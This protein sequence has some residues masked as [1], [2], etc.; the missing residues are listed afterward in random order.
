MAERHGSPSGFLKELSIAEDG[1][2]IK[3]KA[4]WHGMPQMPEVLSMRPSPMREEF[5]QGPTG[6]RE[7]SSL[8]DSPLRN[9]L[10]TS[11][12]VVG[13]M[14]GVSP[15]NRLIAAS[16]PGALPAL[17]LETPH[18]R[19][20]VHV[21]G[22]SSTQ[23]GSHSARLAGAALGAPAAPIGD[24]P[25]GASPSSARA[26]MMGNVGLAGVGVHS[27]LK[28]SNRSDAALLSWHLANQL[29]G[30]LTYRQELDVHNAAFEE[31]KKQVAVHCS[32][33]GEVLDRLQAFYTRS[34]EVT[35]KLAEKG[36]RASYEDQIFALQN[37]IL[38]LRHALREAED[39][40]GPNGGSS[41]DKFID[42]FRDMD[43][44]SQKDVLV[45]LMEES[46]WLLLTADDGDALTIP[47]QA[48]AVR[49]AVFA[50]CE[51]EEQSRALYATLAAQEQPSEK[52]MMIRASL[53][54]TTD[55]ERFGIIFDT[56]DSDQRKRLMLNAFA[57]TVDSDKGPLIAEFMAPL[58][59]DQ[60]HATM[61]SA[62]RELDRQS[63]MSQ[64]E[65]VNAW[66]AKLNDG[67]QRSVVSGLLAVMKKECVI[68]GAPDGV[69][70]WPVAQTSQLVQEILMV[71][72]KPECAITLLTLLDRVKPA[73]RRLILSAILEHTANKD[74]PMLLP[75]VL[76][77]ST[78]LGAMGAGIADS[79]SLETL[80]RQVKEMGPENGGKYVG[81]LYR[82][83][84]KPVARCACLKEVMNGKNDSFSDDETTMLM[85]HFGK[86]APALLRRWMAGHAGKA[87]KG[88]R[89]ASILGRD[90]G[91]PGMR[92]LNSILL[93]GAT[94]EEEPAPAV[95]K[96]HRH[97]M[98]A[99]ELR[100]SKMS[101]AS[102][103][104]GMLQKLKMQKLNTDPNASLTAE[105]CVRLLADCFARKVV[106]DIAA[107]LKV[108][109]R[110]GMTK[111]VQDHITV[112]EGITSVAKVM[113]TV[114]QLSLASDGPFQPRIHFFSQLLG[115][116]DDETWKDVKVDFFLAF[117]CIVVRNDNVKRLQAGLTIAAAPAAPAGGNRRMSNARRM[118]TASTA[119]DASTSSKN[120]RKQSAAVGSGSKQVQDLTS[121]DAEA[122]TE[123][124]CSSKFW[125]EC[126]A[127]VR[128][129]LQLPGHVLS[130]AAVGQALDVLITD[131]S[132]RARVIETIEAKA[133]PISGALGMGI[134]A[135]VPLDDVI[136]M[137][138]QGWDDSR[139]S[140]D[141]AYTAELIAVFKD[142]DTDKDGMI[143]MSDFKDLIESKSPETDIDRIMEMYD[144]AIEYTSE[145]LDEESDQITE[146]AFVL[147][148]EEVGLL[149]QPDGAFMNVSSLVKNAPRNKEDLQE[150]AKGR[151]QGGRRSIHGSHKEVKAAKDASANTGTERKLKDFQTVPKSD[152]VAEI[153]RKVVKANFLFRHLDAAMIERVIG[154]FEPHPVK[155]GDYVITQG[156]RGDYFYVCQS[157]EY[158]VFMDG[159]KVL[160]YSVQQE[161]PAP[162]AADPLAGSTDASAA[163]SAAAAVHS[164]AGRRGRRGSFSED[165]RTRRGSFA[166]MAEAS[167]K[168]PCFG[169]LALMY[170]KPRAAS[171]VASQQGKLWKLGR[172]AFRVVQMMRT[173]ATVDF[174]KVLRKVEVLSTLRFDQLQMLRDRMVER[175]FEPGDYVFRQG[176]PGDAFYLI[177]KGQAQV[178]K[179][180]S[181]GH[182]DNVLMELKQSNYF[183]ERALLRDEPRAASV[184]VAGESALATACISRSAF[185]SMLGP[186]QEMLEDNRRTREAAFNSQQQQLEKFGLG[187]ATRDNFMIDAQI[188]NTPCGVT[189]LVRH[190]ATD[191]T[192]TMREEGKRAI[193]VNGESTRTNRELELLKE[194]AQVKRPTPFLPT[195][196]R[197][198]Q[199]PQS[200]CVLF[201]Q[202]ALCEL[203]EVAALSP[204]G[205]LDEE[206]LIFAGACIARALD[207]LHAE[208]SHIY[209]NMAPERL[210]VLDNGYLCLM[211][212]RF[213]KRDDGSCTTLCGSPSYFAPE[214]L[215]GD[216]QGFGVDWWGFGVLL[217]EMATGD[218]PWGA[219]DDD[220][221]VLLKRIAA[222]TPGTLA[223]PRG[224]NPQ[225]AAL[226]HDLLEPDIE[227]R[228]GDGSVVS[229]AW[230]DSISWPRLL[231]SELPSPLQQLARDAFDEAQPDDME[232]EIEP[233]D[234]HAFTGSTN[235][236]PLASEEPE[237]SPGDTAD[238]GEAQWAGYIATTEDASAPMLA[239]RSAA[240]TPNEAARAQQALG[241]HHPRNSFEVVEE[242]DEDEDYED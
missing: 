48:A 61:A 73:D 27:H 63:T 6:R 151:L 102:A 225:L 147:V 91:A 12:V 14:N 231:D 218:S 126:A 4:K 50:H 124:F 127:Q 159:K 25:A 84:P 11:R 210:H 40:S 242:D 227:Q 173:S 184:R 214:M 208:T 19:P 109:A 10:M 132:Q 99:V 128:D 98:G 120:G 178:I 90:G 155:R 194:L 209:R 162:A 234:W 133:A 144:Q 16:P 195:V 182:G 190:I 143:L 58:K 228:R 107:D 212:H 36:V 80:S 2:P 93:G 198:F 199:S 97:T 114:R 186:L 203:S 113:R 142:A 52:V 26:R 42:A 171:V 161:A 136:R 192:Y 138:M 21:G 39:R 22:P 110:P 129:A 185:E 224:V 67:A 76:S 156:D 232:D 94:V 174:T 230:F 164:P 89:R 165:G 216:T 237:T 122:L 59:K 8:S 201:K 82:A 233:P 200:L 46:G 103:G 79:D 116:L 193:L 65:F 220:D 238:F 170:S 108:R 23:R 150:S 71:M 202:H 140:C 95:R 106:A 149:P 44:L 32:E 13:G 172:D 49:Q 88:K 83:L 105:D 119:S 235:G 17:Q 153:I 5:L 148:M 197:A 15:T 158:D 180:D 54:E 191:K 55:E 167:G 87:G 175:T 221:M 236:E 1:M 86:H 112:T 9:N 3:H 217:Y 157:G 18:A 213:S 141:L 166:G 56:L 66:S 104:P 78:V 51:T 74:L 85:D 181:E 222:Y 72:P 226:L 131:V 111:F 24:A 229:D 37:Q 239:H 118:S 145:Q 160:T 28:P 189:W 177:A 152:Q 81:A 100:S 207:S 34:N 204:G 115:L 211:D 20:H 92:K 121:L 179:S 139:V 125:K 163:G 30:G 215:R 183:G 123:L 219:T 168:H 69:A 101:L 96:A 205:T 188:S 75:S 60:V 117:V 206:S 64:S 146:D 68:Q 38:E 45:T 62:L 53:A 35:M 130:F 154:Y 47:D 240:I 7:V 223:V 241:G 135:M 187:N 31:V 196:L 137:V 77:R 29:S 33:R 57:A 176:D 70:K 134:E 43:E 169:E 41:P